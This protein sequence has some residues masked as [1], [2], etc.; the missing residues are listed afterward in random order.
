MTL[1]PTFT[2]LGA[3]P[4]I[5]MLHD[6][7]GGHRAFA[8]QVESFAAAGYRAVAWD[9]PGYGHSVPIDPYTFKGLAQS[10]SVLIESL[11]QTKG[12]GG[13]ILLGHGM[14]GMVALE[15]AARRPELVR[16]LILS[17]TCAVAGPADATDAARH[18][19]QRDY[20][21]ECLAPLE[22]GL[23]MPALAQRVVPQVTGPNA[24]PE[25]AALAVH[26]MAQVHPATY[27]RALDAMVGF[28]RRSSLPEIHVPTLLIGGEA[29]TTTA[30]AVMRQMAQAIAGSSYVELPGVGHLQHLEAPDDYDG[31][32]LNFLAL[33]SL[34]Q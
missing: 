8:P 34:L 3:G 20:V 23:D 30:P 9:M 14:G 24:L 18:S 5:L 33:P 26:V 32:V 10:C 22:A 12:G 13:V 28:D 21:A 16:R 7:L 27:R 17:G 2:T 19:W 25:G 1:L 15:V 29:D 4:T 11:M 6:I 31:L